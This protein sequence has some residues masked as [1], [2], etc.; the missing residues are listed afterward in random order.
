M[1]VFPCNTVL[2][3][4]NYENICIHYRFEARYQIWIGDYV[5]NC[6]DSENANFTTGDGG[7]VRIIRGWIW[8][9]G[10]ERCF[11]PVLQNHVCTVSLRNSHSYSVI[12]YKLVTNLHLTTDQFKLVPIFLLAGRVNTLAGVLLLVMLNSNFVCSHLHTVYKH[13]LLYWEWGVLRL[14]RNS[15]LCETG[16]KIIP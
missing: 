15:E 5:S 11:A 12:L 3:M 10:F 9:R 4:V 14:I 16:G 1:H 2:V 6:W 8:I 7:M 13:K